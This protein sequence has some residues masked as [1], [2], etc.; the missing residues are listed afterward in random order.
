A[1][2]LP[3]ARA[4]LAWHL[5]SRPTMDL[6]EGEVAAATV[7][8]VAENLTDSIVAPAFLYLAFG[9]PGAMVYRAINTADAM[10]GYRDGALE[11]FGKVA[12]RL[13]DVLNFV[14]ARLGGLACVL[15][16][17]PGRATEAWRI[18]RRD[19][20]Q[21]ASPNAGWP[22]AAMAGALGVV[23]EKPDTYRLGDGAWPARADIAR[24]VRLFARAAAIGTVV[25][26][27]P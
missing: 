2:D 18:L 17:G 3:G 19:R 22:M 10:I 27:L 8:S 26:L 7:E 21:T 13:D 5:V 25:V 12:A 23:L 15:A 14:P 6:G 9:L 16:A 4:T 11:Y 24:A 1:G 20:L